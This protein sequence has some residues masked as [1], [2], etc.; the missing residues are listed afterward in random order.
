M[1]ALLVTLKWYSTWKERLY[2]RSRS[3]KISRQPNNITVCEL[4]YNL[5]T[6]SWVIPESSQ[7]QQGRR[8]AL[9]CLL[10]NLLSQTE[11]GSGQEM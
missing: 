11:G 2:K 6:H 4:V 9:G 1:T 8:K 10:L 5:Q 7:E 3:E